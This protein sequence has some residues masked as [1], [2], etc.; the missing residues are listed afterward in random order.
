MKFQEVTFDNLREVCNLSSTLTPAQSR[1]VAYNAYSIA[2]AHLYDGKS[3]YRALEVDGELVGFIMLDM[4][5]DDCPEDEQPAADLWRFMIA[6]NH[7]GRGYGKQAL[8]LVI[9]Q[10]REDGYRTFY[11]SCVMEEASPYGFYISYGFTD[12][13]VME[14][15]EQVLKLGL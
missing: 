1:C 15:Q 10:L 12:T 4:D 8:D 13:G 3:W 2:Q 6:G 5:R 7:Q 11:T 14:D 9:K